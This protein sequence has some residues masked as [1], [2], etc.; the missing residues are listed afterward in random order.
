MGFLFLISSISLYLIAKILFEKR[1]K[2]NEKNHEETL[3]SMRVLNASQ[4]PVNLLAI[5]VL[6][7]IRFDEISNLDVMSNR[8]REE[9]RKLINSELSILN[10]GLQISDIQQMSSTHL[11]KFGEEVIKGLNEGSYNL[12]STQSGEKLLTAINQKGQIVENAKLAS[13][14]LHK[15]AE[16]SNLI[17]GASHIIAGYDN[18]KKLQKISMGIDKIL[19]YRQVDM[20]SE[21]KAAYEELQTIS[22][23][24]KNDSVAGRLRDV[25][26]RLRLLRVRWLSEVSNGLDY[27]VDDPRGFGVIDRYF[28][29]ESN[30]K[31]IGD[32]VNNCIAP[33][34][35]VRSILEIERFIAVALNEEQIFEDIDVGNTVCDLH[36][37]RLKLKNKESSLNKYL[38]DGGKQVTLF[39]EN[40]DLM[41]TSLKKSA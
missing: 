11:A 23:A 16:I 35:V 20:I 21:F 36:E 40:S 24:N 8:V 41:I 19:R 34:F 38:N 15:L 5:N 31:K 7:K 18:A 26:S 14:G 25:K 6:T 1:K 2:E 13:G 22:L 17:V 28:F 27:D 4:K 37:I 9:Q 33:L 12:M 30:A 3:D 32:Q 29:K 39:L 10:I